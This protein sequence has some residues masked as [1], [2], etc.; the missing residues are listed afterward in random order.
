MKVYEIDGTV[1]NQWLMPI[2]HKGDLDDLMNFNCQ[3]KSQQFEGTIWDVDSSLKPF[4]N[5]Y[6]LGIGG[7]FAFDQKVYNHHRLRFFLELSGEIIPVKG[8]NQTYYILNV[9]NHFNSL[10]PFQTEWHYFDNGE[11]DRVK[12]HVFDRN[13]MIESPVFKIPETYRI[14]CLT[15][16]GI[17]DPEDELKTVY[18]KS[19]LKGL[20]FTELYSTD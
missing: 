16:T 3:P 12:K 9:L 18:E 1:T 10:D 8:I 2:R 11:K 7:A 6:T 4:G 14:A 5:F 20:D 15:T 19:G 17:K 13:R